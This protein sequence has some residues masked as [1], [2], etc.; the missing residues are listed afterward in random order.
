MAESKI[1]ENPGVAPKGPGWDYDAW[2]TD[3]HGNC[4][5]ELYCKWWPKSK[6]WTR[7]AIEL[8]CF[9]HGRTERQGG[10]GKFGHA[11]QA[12]DL[13]FNWDKEEEPVFL[14]TPEATIF[15]RRAC[16]WKYLAVCGSGSSGKSHPAAVWGLLRFL[17][18]P[19][20]TKVLLTSTTISGGCDRVW[21]SVVEL[22]SKLPEEMRAFSK[23]NDAKHLIKYIGDDE[24]VKQG[25]R[26]GLELVAAEPKQ[27]KDAVAKLIGRK[28]KNLVFVADELTDIS[29]SVNTAFFSNLSRNSGSQ[30]IGLGNPSDW[31][32]AMGELAMP[33]KGV[34]SVNINTVE[35]KTVRGW[36]IHFDDMTSLNYLEGKRQVEEWRAMRYRENPEIENDADAMAVLEM[37]LEKI[38]SVRMHHHWRPSYWE[39]ETD[40]IRDGENSLM[41]LR[42]S[43]GWFATNG[44]SDTIYA[45][46]DLMS[47][48]LKTVDW[49]KNVPTKTISV[50]LSFSRGGDRCVMMLWDVGRDATGKLV[51]A[52]KDTEILQDDAT[53]EENT[54]SAQICKQIADYAKLHEVGHRYIAYDATGAGAPFGDM[55]VGYLSKEIYGVNFGGKASARP[56]SA[57]N[58]NPSHERYGN[59][60]SEIW[61]SGVEVLRGKQFAFLPPDV[62]SE[63][64]TR[65]YEIGAGNKITVQPKKEMRMKMGKSPDLSD[66][67]HINLDLCRERLHFA[68]AERGASIMPETDYYEMVRKMDMAAFS[69]GSQPDWIPS[70]A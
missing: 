38:G 9:H 4:F 57:T 12:I 32:N 68:S 18:S 25:T 48:V 36:A 7:I 50:D 62:M 14:W 23:L 69:A 28:A 44:A 61:Y 24:N 52:W 19:K 66:C 29:P 58:R 21:G 40:R 63:M 10:L 31:F 47:C 3:E 49:G 2:G 26:R 27:A 45:M 22:Y 59:R 60:V 20:D 53:D 64:A 33:A 42:M 16:E 43:R 30:M 34:A 8:D 70:A 65:T 15:I 46:S 6:N 39:I 67:L 37:E 41:F 17:S 11:R 13:L 5:Y 54:R 56:V 1:T 51:M 35:W 55:L